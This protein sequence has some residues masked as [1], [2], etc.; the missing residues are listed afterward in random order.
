MHFLQ[1]LQEMLSI[2]EH[3]RNHFNGWIGMHDAFQN[4]EYVDIYGRTIDTAVFS[5]F[6]GV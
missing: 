1:L 6:D 5:S 2:F 4:G 3:K